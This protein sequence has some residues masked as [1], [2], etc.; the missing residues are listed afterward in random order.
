M[1]ELIALGMIFSGLSVSPAATPHSSTDA[2]AKTTPW[3]TSSIG[4]MPTGKM[5]PL[6]VIVE[7][8]GV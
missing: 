6:S 2:Y 8:P 1:I 5:P 7:K 4:S 3:I